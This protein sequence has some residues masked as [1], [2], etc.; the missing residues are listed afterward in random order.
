MFIVS[1]R[2][3]NKEAVDESGPLLEKLIKESS[4]ITGGKVVLK[5]CVPDDEDKIEV[6]YIRKS[7]HKFCVHKR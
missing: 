2:C 7:E 5:T 3:F 6:S 1:D 4:K